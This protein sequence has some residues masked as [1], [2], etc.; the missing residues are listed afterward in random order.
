MKNKI[1]NNKVKNNSLN[2]FKIKKIALFTFSVIGLNAFIFSNNVYAAQVS[3]GTNNI[4]TGDNNNT[5]GENL[6]NTSK[7]S[8]LYGRDS[9]LTG[10]NINKDELNEILNTKVEKINNKNNKQK[11]IDIIDL[12]INNNN[13][14]QDQIRRRIEVLKE[15]NTTGIEKGERLNNLN[16]QKTTK[17]Q[18]IENLR[19]ELNTI[20][21]QAVNQDTHISRTVWSNFENQ[22]R[23]LNWDKIN[24]ANGVNELATELKER[25]ERDFPTITK[26]EV[27]KYKP[28]INGY[29]NSKGIFGVNKT[30]ANEKFQ[31]IEDNYY[32]NLKNIAIN[33]LV[34]ENKTQTEKIHALSDLNLLNKSFNKIDSLNNGSSFIN[35]L[36]LRYFLSERLFADKSLYKINEWSEEDKTVYQAINGLLENY[37]LE[38][39]EEKYKNIINSEYFKPYKEILDKYGLYTIQNNNKYYYDNNNGLYLNDKKAYEELITLINKKNLSTGNNQLEIQ[40]YL[41]YEKLLKNEEIMNFYHQYS[42]GNNSLNYNATSNVVGAYNDILNKNNEGN[43]NSKILN[44]LKM[45]SFKN[46]KDYYEFINKTGLL[47]DK[48]FN[49]RYDGKNIFTELSKLKNNNNVETENI[50]KLKQFVYQFKTADQMIDWDA[51]QSQWNIDK[52]EYK[53]KFDNLRSVYQ[54]IEDYL[55]AYDNLIADI[56][57]DDKKAEMLRKYNE[58]INIDPEFI[59]AQDISKATYSEKGKETIRHFDEIVAAENRKAVDEMN[60]MIDGLKLFDR[61][62]EI[63]VEVNK[64]VEKITDQIKNKEE[65]IKRKEEELR[66]IVDAISNVNLTDEERNANQLKEEKERELIEKQRE[67]E[68]LEAE[69][70][71]KEKEL[72]EL[73]KLVKDGD[74]TNKGIHNIGVGY[75]NFNSGERAITIGNNN[76]VLAN[77]SV[78]IGNNNNLSKEATDT[79]I[80]GSNVNTNVANSIALGKDTA[81]ENAI[82][83]EKATINKKEYNFV[84]ITPVGTVSIGANGKER[85]LTNLAAGRISNES[86]DGVNGSQLFAIAKALDE[87]ALSIKPATKYT[88]GEGINITGDE[89]TG[90]TIS[91]T[92]NNNGN[93]N[94]DMSNYTP[95]VSDGLELNAEKE[96]KVKLGK[97]LTFDDT[98]NI[99]INTGEGLELDEN[100]KLKAKGTTITAGKN[101]GVDGDAING[102]TIKSYSNTISMKEKSGLTVN[103]K[104]NADGTTNYEIS[105]N[106]GKGL[107]IDD[108]NNITMNI[109][110]NSGIGFDENGKLKIKTGSGI[111]FDENGNLTATGKTINPLKGGDGVSIADEDDFTVIKTKGVSTFTDDNVTYNRTNLNQPLVIKGGNNIHTSTNNEG[112]VIVNMKDD[113]TLNSISINN[114]P[115]LN[116]QGL[117]MNNQRI[118]NVADGINDNDAVNMS[119]LRRIITSHAAFNGEHIR[120]V[121]NRLNELDN[122]MNKQNKLRKASSAS[123]TA[124]A[125]LLQSFKYGQSG[126]TAAVGQHQGQ[127]AIA[128]GY[129]RLSDNGKYGIKMSINTN[130]QK[131]FGGTIG[132]GYFW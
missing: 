107:S 121:D 120:I 62:N 38:I 98:K 105:T 122:R 34:E 17:D 119:Q 30:K 35:G 8:S 83:T 60:K 51:D 63:V 103:N 97:G 118:T 131:E 61:H 109:K 44:I 11:E 130:T 43:L 2:H 13:L 47:F 5:Y 37:E 117:D 115:T 3:H 16:N 68:A 7:Q 50:N 18:E 70:I 14:T 74:L 116:N 108:N 132:A 10:N 59:T 90:Y 22:L 46:K 77:D 66:H 57:N 36:Q 93:Q 123:S 52:E 86:T 72:E 25:V 78:A 26:Y 21:E 39:G 49:D 94:V 58:V 92:N 54:K 88:A 53:R 82:A 102:Y 104:E 128:V 125:G 95:K 126:I 42:Y 27:E 65:E 81:L 28:L 100:G 40:G 31:Y 127:T 80:L 110:D 101:I 84:G 9:I 6:I 24:Q 56:S 124:T 106:L 29:V 1:K 15:K 67:K 87:L 64:E 129:S 45:P 41:T 19:N 69:K 89:N 111:A 12:N 114:G 75:N 99:S 91:V 112:N 55:T 4:I 79:F 113:V 73:A 23:T 85:T 32:N 20:K 48:E 76:T 71:K 96:I 33:T